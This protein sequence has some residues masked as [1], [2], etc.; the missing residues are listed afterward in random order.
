[1][2]GKVSIIIIE[3]TAGVCFLL[4]KLLD[5]SLDGPKLSLLIIAFDQP[6]QHLLLLLR[7]EGEIF[8]GMLGLE[9]ADLVLINPLAPQFL[10]DGICPVLHEEKG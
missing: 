10:Q 8:G 6:G 5:G 2:F 7:E 3:I 4:D 1:M 9:L